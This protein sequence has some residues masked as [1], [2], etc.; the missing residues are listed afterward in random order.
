MI[1]FWN[2]ELIK[3]TFRGHPRAPAEDLNPD[4]LDDA[5]GRAETRETGFKQLLVCL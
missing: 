5:S 4:E 3:V 1:N 2:N